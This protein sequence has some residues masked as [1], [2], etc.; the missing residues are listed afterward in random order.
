[1]P[2]RVSR[3]LCSTLC[4]LL[5]QS[6]L[7]PCPGIPV[8]FR[9][10]LVRPLHCRAG[11]QASVHT[12]VLPI[13]IAQPV[14]L[15]DQGCFSLAFAAIYEECFAKERTWQNFIGTLSSTFLSLE[16]ALP[17]TR[18]VSN[19]LGSRLKAQPTICCPARAFPFNSAHSAMYSHIY[20][21]PRRLLFLQ[22]GLRYSTWLD[23]VCSS[24]PEGCYRGEVGD[25]QVHDHQPIDAA[26]HHTLSSGHFVARNL[27]QWQGYR[28]H[29]TRGAA[30]AYNSRPAG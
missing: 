21:I 25:W 27:S 11:A 20:R 2:P 12:S 6:R 7:S 29:P 17:T 5:S 18:E 1:M 9:L 19:D 3:E 10:C 14:T 16:S 22:D 15:E 4:R 8:P 28:V 30:D 13:P 23:P 26:V 24:R